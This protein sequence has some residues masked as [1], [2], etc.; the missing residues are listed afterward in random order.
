MHLCDKQ[1]CQSSAW[2]IMQYILM[3]GLQYYNIFYCL[4]LMFIAS[5]NV[6]Q[7]YTLEA[8]HSLLVS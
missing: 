6:L 1:M 3:N 8:V 5:D 7:W 4:F 2:K